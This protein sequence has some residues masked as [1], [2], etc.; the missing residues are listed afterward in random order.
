MEFDRLLSKY[1]KIV[2]K[3]AETECNR[4]IRN[5][6]KLGEA[7]VYYYKA[8]KEFLIRGGKRL[9]PVSFILA[10]LGVAGRKNLKEAVKA[11]LSIELMHNGTLSHD[12][13]MDQDRLR[14]GGPTSWV[15]FSDWYKKK[16]GII[17]AEHFG[18]S[19]A[20]LQGDTFTSF[21]FSQLFDR[22]FPAKQVLETARCMNKYYTIV[23][24]GQLRDMVFEKMKKEIDEKEYLNMV[25]MKTGALFE[26][27]VVM[28]AT[29]AG[30]P[31]KKIELLKK[32][33]VPVGQAFQI[34]DDI[35]G[36]FGKPEKFGKPT[37]SDIKEGK[38]TLLVIRALQKAKPAERRIIQRTLGNRKA[39]P[40]EVDAVRRIMQKTGAVEYC[41]LKAKKLALKGKSYIKKLKLKDESEKFFLG[42][43][44]YVVNRET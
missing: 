16:F 21:G 19:I 38:R 18:E 35:L 8:A 6:K 20:I 28:G 23:V 40:S 32:Y 31:Q 27:A 2:D 30:A 41:R 1:V 44:D 12:D 10:Y 4:S 29:L 7:N 17:G 11:A 13:I 33:A 39:R 42:L 43:A 26:A 15:V 34:Q 14:R 3:V 36:V 22:N 5:A 37:D 25:N 9:R 24:E